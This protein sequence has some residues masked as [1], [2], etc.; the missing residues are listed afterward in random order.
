[1]TFLAI[2]GA[3]FIAAVVI[4]VGASLTGVINIFIFTVGVGSF[5]VTTGFVW[6]GEE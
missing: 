5:D 4:F 2:I 3:L 1:M 6:G